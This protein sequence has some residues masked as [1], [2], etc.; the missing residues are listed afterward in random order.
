MAES[1]AHTP[2]ES[3]DQSTLITTKTAQG[4]VTLDIG[5]RIFRVYKETLRAS[6][7]SM[8]GKMFSGQHHV[9]PNADGHYFFDRDPDLVTPIINFYRSRKLFVGSGINVN[10]V[11]E[12]AR[13]ATDVR[14][15]L[16]IGFRGDFSG[17]AKLTQN[18]SHF[19]LGLEF[20]MADTL[21]CTMKSSGL[22]TPH[23]P[24]AYV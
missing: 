22:R 5:G 2:F 9:E 1:N 10:G 21:E 17:V 23:R 6:P 8:L 16:A 12:E 13:L 14:S 11:R 20:F 7:D 24:F 18:S 3:V 15:I 19:W 4:L